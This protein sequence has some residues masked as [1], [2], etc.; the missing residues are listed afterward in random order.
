[1]D[2]H[3]IAAWLLLVCLAP[4][5]VYG[6]DQIT[7]QRSAPWQPS[8]LL[9]RELG[10]EPD[11]CMK[12]LLVGEKAGNTLAEAAAESTQKIVTPQTLIDTD[13]KRS[14]AK[15]AVDSLLAARAIKVPQEYDAVWLDYQTARAM[16]AAGDT[17]DIADL[18]LLLT[19]PKSRT[20]EEQLY[21]KAWLEN[22]A[23][24]EVEE[25]DEN[26][27]YNRKKLEEAIVFP[28]ALIV[29]GLE[30]WAVIKAE[31]KP[32]GQLG[33]VWTYASSDHRVEKAVIK[34]FKK[35]QPK[36]CGPN[37]RQGS[38]FATL[39]A[40][41]TFEN[42]ASSNLPLEPDPQYSFEGL[43]AYRALAESPKCE[44]LP[45]KN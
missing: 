11:A 20:Y 22:M 24:G 8:E 45:V 36:L 18:L 7:V 1:M 30:A 40:R 25:G 32:D 33:A 16:Q 12:W 34:A 38:V 31:F 43:A 19:Q 27:C 6:A 10:L 37:R 42:A 39:P 23:G 17:A 29:S 4:V 41:F 2:K 5:A 3:L 35:V 14:A 44:A 9:I 26:V 28:G 13:Q 21:A 15:A